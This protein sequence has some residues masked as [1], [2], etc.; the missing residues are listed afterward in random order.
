MKERPLIL[1]DYAVRAVLAGLKTQDRRIVKPQPDRY[2]DGE[3]YWF[4]GGY[5]AWKFRDCE[6]VLRRGGNDLKCPYGELG[7]R[8]WLK[9]TWRSWDERQQVIY[10]ADYGQ[11]ECSMKWKSSS[12]MPRIASR[13]DLQASSICIERL[14]EISASDAI[15]EGTKLDVN[16]DKEAST[17]RFGNRPYPVR[18]YALFWE[19]THGPGSWDL[20]PLVWVARGLKK[21]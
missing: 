3:P 9:E 7:D 19:S 4:V 8:L 17:S 10:K 13:I 6:C 15:A 5:R 11:I 12:C 16:Y 21:V 20:N 18:A 14:Q 1:K 2:H